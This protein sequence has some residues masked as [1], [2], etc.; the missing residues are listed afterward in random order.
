MVTQFKKYRDQQAKTTARQTAASTTRKRT[1]AEALAG[2][3]GAMQN[4]IGDLDFPSFSTE[5]REM[6]TEALTSLKN[7]LDEALDR[8]AQG[9]QMLA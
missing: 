6:V 3:I 1:K 7:T 9:S 4:K 5:D 2:Q 8:A